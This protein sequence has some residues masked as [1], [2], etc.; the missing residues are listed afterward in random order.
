M[1]PGGHR[2]DTPLTVDGG[3]KA[4]AFELQRL[5]REAP[6]PFLQGA[7][8]NPE[9]SPDEVVLLLRNRAATPQLLV[10][11]GR[12]RRW[13]RSYDIK[14]GLVRHPRTPLPI[15]GTLIHHLYWRDLAETAS[16]LTLHPT[17]RRKSEEILR[18][19]LME[20]ALGERISLARIAS[21][22]L[23]GALR[24]TGEE[25]VL[26]AL[27]GNSR[28]VETD[29]VQMA[30]GTGVPARVLARLAEHPSW[31]SRHAVLM[32]LATNPRTPV[33]V[34]LRVV[35]RLPR[36]DLRRLARDPKAPKIVRVGA[37]RRL[38]GDLAIP[39]GGAPP[40]GDSG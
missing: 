9:L 2:A 11:V 28:L 34:A 6:L 12:D 13:T 40:V 10:R 27:L 14:R 30:K 38:R 32:A 22:G 29:A 37:E 39:R 5:L 23:I 20:L 35:R 31:G 3:R 17:V 24:Q 19:R 15:V 18:I 1:A 33:A 21:R 36:R 26:L 25:R 7:L 8:D 16:D 4:S